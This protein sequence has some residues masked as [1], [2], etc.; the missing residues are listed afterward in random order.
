MSLDFTV[1]IFPNNV[2]QIIAARFALIDPILTIVQRPLRTTDPNYSIGVWADTWLPVEGSNEILGQ[3]FARVSTLERYTV[4]IQALVKDADEVA[5]LNASAVISETLRTILG[6]DGP[7]RSQLGGLPATLGN[8][9]KL[10]KQWWVR[11]AKYMSGEL[12][13]TNLY[14]TRLGLLLEVE[15]I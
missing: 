15:K 4:M 10:L 11:S 12:N 8:S 7:L 3:D 9:T 14:L 1:E 6:T 5:G 2:V 13:G